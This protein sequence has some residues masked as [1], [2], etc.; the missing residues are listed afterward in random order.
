MANYNIFT[1][2][3]DLFAL[4]VAIQYKVYITKIVIVA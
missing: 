3:L 2:T 1:K 4:F